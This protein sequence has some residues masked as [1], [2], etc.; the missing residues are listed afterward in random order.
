MKLPPTFKESD[1]L[2]MTRFLTTP[3]PDENSFLLP[4][5]SSFATNNDKENTLSLF[6]YD[7]P[8]VTP[9]VFFVNLYNPSHINHGF[10]DYSGHLCVD[11]VT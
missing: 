1:R 10:C 6:L 4:N 11:L 3:T 2:Y 5:K 7:T 8:G 9:L